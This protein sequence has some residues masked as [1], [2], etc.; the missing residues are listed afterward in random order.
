MAD[1]QTLKSDA[2]QRMRGR[3]PNTYFVAAVYMAAG[4]IMAALIYALSGLDRYALY[5]ENLL[6]VNPY[7]TQAELAAA[8]PAV[9]AAALALIA[10]V[11]LVRL[12]LNVGYMAY[13]LKAS[14]G[15]DADTRTVFEGFTMFFR[16][17]RLEILR[18][19]YIGLWSCLLVVP[20][21][22]AYYSSRQA[23]YL[24]LDKP[25][26]RPLDCLRASG[27]LMAGHRLELFN[28]DLSFL[29]WQLADRA[30]EYLSTLRLFSIWLAPYIGV[31]RAAFYDRLA[32]EGGSD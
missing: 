8:L 31:T 29:G 4:G 15:E 22:M 10:A 9:P 3:T 19:L 16:I 6:S 26:L 20:G 11:M 28:L 7:P 27:R 17:L 14:R 24:L 12:M 23:F 2:R 30:V 18:L 1:R 25:E 21:I 5:L 13:C 32:A